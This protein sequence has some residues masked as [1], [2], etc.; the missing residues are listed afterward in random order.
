MH[1]LCSVPYIHVQECTFTFLVPPFA[2]FCMLLSFVL[3]NSPYPHLAQ[4]RSGNLLHLQAEEKALLNTFISSIFLTQEKKVL[5]FS[6]VI[7][8]ISKCK[9]SPDS[10][11]K[12]LFFIC[13]C[14]QTQDW[15]KTQSLLQTSV[16]PLSWFTAS[17]S[18]SCQKLL[19]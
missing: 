2:F 6:L 8:Q 16:T 4:K 5:L 1:Q 11:S 15:F 9:W 3:K 10:G 13:L 7:R 17:P 18:H 19:L 14:V 12:Y